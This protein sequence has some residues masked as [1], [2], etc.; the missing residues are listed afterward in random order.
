[1]HCAAIG[2]FLAAFFRFS[3]DRLWDSDQVV[4]FEDRDDDSWYLAYN[5]RTGWRSLSVRSMTRFSLPMD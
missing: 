3:A 2:R 5:P 1:M 4:I